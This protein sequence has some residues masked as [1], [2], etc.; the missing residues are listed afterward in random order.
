MKVQLIMASYEPKDDY[1]FLPGENM[2]IISLMTLFEIRLDN[3]PL[4]KIA[5]VFLNLHSLYTLFG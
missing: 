5:Q 3:G 1:L 4:L 2:V